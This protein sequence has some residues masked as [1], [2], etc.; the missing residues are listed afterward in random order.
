M[1][2]ALASQEPWRAF[3][4]CKNIED[5]SFFFDEDRARLAKQFCRTN[6]PVRYD[7]LDYAYR[8]PCEY[9]VFGGFDEADREKMLRRHGPK[10]IAL[11]IERERL[12]SP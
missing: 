12:T 3:A 5:K 1:P 2:E 10:G 9:G 6:C 11:L 4:A 8:T 7:C